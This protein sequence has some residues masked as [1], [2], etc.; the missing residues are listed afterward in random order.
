MDGEDGDGTDENSFN[1]KPRWQ[2]FLILFA[3]AALNVI[4]GFLIIC[5]INFFTV[6]YL[7]TNIIAEFDDNAVSNSCGLKV[8]DDIVK[9]NN[10]KISNQYDYATILGTNGVKPVDIT[11]VRDGKEVVIKNVKFVE[12][13]NEDLG[14]IFKLDFKVYPQKLGFFGVIKYSFDETVSVSKSIYDFIGKI[15][16]GSADINQV[17]GP[18][19]TSAAIGESV[20]Y[21]FD[22]LMLMMAI[23]SVNL[24]VVNLLPFPALD[25]GRILVL[26]I[27][28]IRRKPLNPKVETAINAVGLVFLLLL[29]VLISFKDVIKLF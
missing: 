15:F 17:S 26:I 10:Y 21:G 18:V 23:I 9:I 14:K 16:T 13:E 24:G 27:E 6:K 5:I 20:K 3:G 28:A 11:V 29:M 25:G 1:K 2:R 19:G 12:V 4:L 7:P 22:S 8:G